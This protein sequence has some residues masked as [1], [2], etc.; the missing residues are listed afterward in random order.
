MRKLERLDQK[1]N[2][3][4]EPKVILNEEL[5]KEQQE[6]L[7]ANQQDRIQHDEILDYDKYRFRQIKKLHD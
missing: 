7:P 2:K 5:I 3:L 4:R 6:W 1:K